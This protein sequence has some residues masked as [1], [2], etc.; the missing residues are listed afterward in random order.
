MVKIIKVLLKHFLYKIF[1]IYYVLIFKTKLIFKKKDSNN[2]SLNSINIDDYVNELNKNGYVVIKNFFDREKLIKI[3]NE[4]KNN[5]DK[6]YVYINGVKKKF[7]DNINDNQLLKKEASYATYGSDPSLLFSLI[8]KFKLFEK[9]K[10]FVLEKLINKYLNYFAKITSGNLRTSFSNLLKASET[11]LFH[12]DGSG[13]KFLKAFIYLHD[14]ST[15]EGPFTFVRKSHKDKYKFKDDINIRHNDESILSLYGEC[16]IIC[17]TAQMGDLILADTSGFHKG[18]KNVNERTMITIN[19]H[20]HYEFFRP[21]I[22]NLEPSIYKEMKNIWS[23]TST[24]Y[25][26]SL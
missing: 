10:T 14:V 8:V 21:Q 17:L 16:N 15:K 19:F 25:F 4:L 13:H 23:S 6:F 7:N 12:R 18:T 2:L 11:Q 5:P 9:E 24:R 3:S 22:I 20:S 26:S 1:H